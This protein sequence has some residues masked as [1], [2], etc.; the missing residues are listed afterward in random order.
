MAENTAIENQVGA[1]EM[2][3]YDF[4]IPKGL[5]AQHPLANR[6]DSRL[7][8]VDRAAGTI[9][10]THTRDLHEFLKPED[11]IVLNDTRVVP[12]QLI[13]YREQTG[14]RW[15]GLFLEA[16]ENGVWKLMC[17]TRGKIE[18]GESV[19]LLDRDGQVCFHL[20]LLMRL[21]DGQWAA[22]P[23]I[24][25]LDDDPEFG[26]LIAKGE[27]PHWSKLLQRVG[28]IPLPH[29]IRGGNMTDADFKD[30]QT[31]FA[32]QP[33]AV[34]APTAGLHFT[35]DL[36]L[37]LKQRGVSIGRVTLHVGA[38]TFRPIQTESLQEHRMHSEWCSVES[39]VVDMVHQAKA[40]GGRAVMVGTTC[41]RSMETAA[42]NGKLE[43][44]QGHTDLFIRPGYQFQV[45]DGLLTNFHLPRTTLLVLVRTFGGE[46]LIKRAYD[47]A[48]RQEYRFFSY[49]DAMLII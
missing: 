5:I 46:E 6:S 47:E 2:E 41:M 1:S 19:V 11:C 20:Q 26:P 33:G 48:I 23:V 44:F 9:E 27:R 28:R 14:G 34:A 49:G 25:A 36:L 4:P 10:H 38:G 18:P 3:K 17:K 12:A 8:I 24:K 39:R 7:M 15:Q 42:A 16:D 21:E 35:Q 32:K 13:G 45:A 30:Y 29:Y 37:K 40:Q 43:P 31:V 22:L